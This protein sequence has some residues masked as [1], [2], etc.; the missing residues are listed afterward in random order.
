MDAIIIILTLLSVILLV[1]MLIKKNDI[2]ISL[3]T[4]GIVL[5]YIGLIIGNKIKVTVPT[6]HWLIP[7]QAM[8]DQFTVS[9]AGPGFII[10]L[11]AGYSAYMS[12]IGANDVTVRAL[13][14]PLKEIKSVYILVPFVFLLGNLMSLVVP[15]A[16]NLAI[17]LLATLYPVLR[18]A[19]MSR[20]T[21]AAVIATTATIIPTPLGSDNVAIASALHL[22]TT[23]YVFRYHAIVSIPTL[24]LIAAIHY[25]WQKHEDKVAPDNISYE[26]EL[27]LS[28]DKH[29]TDV[30]AHS[31][32]S[33]LYQFLYGLL[34]MMPI[35]LL[36]I[37]FFVSLTKHNQNGMTVPIVTMISFI[38]AIIVELYHSG[39]VKS[40][41]GDTNIFFNGMGSALGIVA[42]LV[43]AQ[44]FVA[45][46]N[47][48]GVMKM[49]QTAMMHVNGSGVILPLL[50]V[51]FTV[52]I[53]L[54]S[55]SG[56]AL[57]FAM[58]PLL[59][60]LSK[61]VGIQPEA[62]S[63]PLQLTGNLMRAVSPV[64]AVVLIVAGTTKLEP[65]SIVKRTAVPMV[66]GLI[67]ATILC[68]VLL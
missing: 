27:K 56:V 25:F 22:S 7:I 40:T 1:Y 15:S 43:A 30:N 6:T 31:E 20:P 54:L 45:G 62:L 48:I 37:S 57:V 28:S 49:L 58:V 13:T 12:H 3:Y 35:V 24:L 65:I 2:K 59:V 11:L 47:S 9:L 52:V 55:G 64:A 68:L 36:V 16:S 60:P 8:I 42:L 39:K 61:S 38:I 23:D 63:V 4:L 5:M 32:D 21:A 53:V 17:I 26:D 18:T 46:L 33:G 44:T 66:G 29:D 50:L 19:K 67:I 10:L 14:K 34:P 41:L 51:L